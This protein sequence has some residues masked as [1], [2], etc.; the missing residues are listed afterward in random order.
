MNPRPVNG[1]K[2]AVTAKSSVPVKPRSASAR[3]GLLVAA[4]PRPAEE[5]GARRA[6]RQHAG[7]G[8]EAQIGIGLG[9]CR[10]RAREP[11]R[12]ARELTVRVAQPGG[13]GGREVEIRPPDHRPGRRG[14]GERIQKLVRI[15]WLDL[16]RANRHL[17]RNADVRQR[18]PPRQ[19]ARLTIDRQPRRSVWQPSSCRHASGSN[20]VP[21]SGK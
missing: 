8:I 18:R 13:P 14:D 19:H 17:V 11:R 16:Q 12:E 6:Q 9:Q 4:R 2:V 10:A 5:I 1:R 20:G 15:A 3:P 7:C 21:A